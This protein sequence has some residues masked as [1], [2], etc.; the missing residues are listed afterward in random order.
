M[1]V[2]VSLAELSEAYGELRREMSFVDDISQVII[3]TVDVQGAYGQFTDQL[4]EIVD[5]DLVGIGLVTND[6]RYFIQHLSDKFSDTIKTGVTIPLAG[7]SAAIALATKETVVIGNVEERSDLWSCRRHFAMGFLS[8]IAAPLISGNSAFGALFLGSRLVNGFRSRDK[9]VVQ[10]LANLIA[11]SIGTDFLMRRPAIAPQN[12]SRPRLT[13]KEKEV[14][15]ILAH[16]GRNKDAAEKMVVSL[17]TVKF[18]V[19]NLYTKL[20]VK[21]RGELIRVAS[22]YGFIY[23]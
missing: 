11:P 12:T 1:N 3:S 6:Q 13:N 5:Y 7:T 8:T 4:R 2:F 20:E 23:N 9:T 21:T 22:N 15:N 19:K 10:R 17:S 18:H 16:G 14:V